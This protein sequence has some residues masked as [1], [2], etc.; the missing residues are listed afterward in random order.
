MPA[1]ARI[2][3]PTSH[4]GLISAP[5]TL[6]GPGIVSIAGQI[7]AAVGDVHTCAFPQP[8]GPHPPN[9][10]AKGSTTV[11]IGGRPAARVGDLT[12]CGA[13]IVSGAFKV[14]IGG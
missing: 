6:A 1:A 10:I 7:A 9:T 12:V 14:M 13:K 4:P 2:L 11:T 3:D 8:A 5:M